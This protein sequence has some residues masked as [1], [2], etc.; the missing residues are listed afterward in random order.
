MSAQTKL[1]VT[2]DE[3]SKEAEVDLLNHQNYNYIGTFYVGNPPQ[4]LRGCFDTGS[5]NAWILSS[6]AED[7]VSRGE[8]QAFNPALSF[9]FEDTDLFEKI[10]FGSGTLEGYFGYDDFLLGKENDTGIHIEG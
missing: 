6:E 3:G 10:Q 7:T 9:T 4:P 8:N 2:N 5:A 1:K